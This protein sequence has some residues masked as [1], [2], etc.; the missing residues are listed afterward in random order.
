[1]QGKRHAPT[2]RTRQ[3]VRDLAVVG[4]SQERIAANLG[5]HHET[6]ERHY[7]AELDN[8]EAEANAAVARVAYAMATDGEH[9]SMTMFWLKTRAGWRETCRHE[10]TG[11]DGGPQTFRVVYED[12]GNL[13]KLTDEELETIAASGL[14]DGG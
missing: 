13:P 14:Q 7:R 1:M 8:A 4:Y 2:E 6:L 9:P 12:E 10:H 3:L 5:I 11:Q